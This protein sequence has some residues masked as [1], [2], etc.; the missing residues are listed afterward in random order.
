MDRLPCNLDYTNPIFYMKA[1]GGRRNNRKLYIP[2]S[3]PEE[4]RQR[5]GVGDFGRRSRTCAGART[6]LGCLDQ[7]AR[8]DRWAEMTSTSSFSSQEG[9]ITEGNNVFAVRHSRRWW[10]L[11]YQKLLLALDPHVTRT[12]SAVTL[13]QTSLS[14]VSFDFFI[15]SDKEMRVTIARDFS[16]HASGSKDRDRNYADSCCH[17]QQWKLN[18]ERSLISISIQETTGWWCT[19]AVLDIF[20]PWST[21]ESRLCATSAFML[22]AL[23][24]AEIFL[25]R[26]ERVFCGRGRGRCFTWAVFFLLAGSKVQFTISFI[27]VGPL[28]GADMLHD[29]F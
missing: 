2:L 24:G 18:A 6:T 13:C 15:S 17:S 19:G 5:T 27:R 22:I 3:Y 1:K 12:F 29:V 20:S 21:A 7:G 10:L 4:S 28:K 9:E 14:P 16:Q 11:R 26:K 8:S 25:R 23:D